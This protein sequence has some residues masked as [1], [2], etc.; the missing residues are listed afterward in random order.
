M[1]FPFRR[2]VFEIADEEPLEPYPV[3]APSSTVENPEPRPVR[4]VGEQAKGDSPQAGRSPRSPLPFFVSSAKRRAALAAVAAA[5]GVGL[6]AGAHLL[7][8]PQRPRPPAPERA[9][10]P[11]ALQRGDRALG[12]GRSADRRRRREPR[13]RGERGRFA[14]EGADRPAARRAPRSPAPVAGDPPPAPAPATPA[15][16]GVAPAAPAAPPAPA[17]VP[18][19]RALGEEFGFER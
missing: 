6:G 19:Q 16:G 10:L 5:L 9:Q 14:G 11:T 1:P 17:V 2:S 3:D 12:G 15:A 4:L 7:G 8:A 13:A 18:V